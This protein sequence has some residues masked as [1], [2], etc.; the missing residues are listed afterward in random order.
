M[1]DITILKAFALKEGTQLDQLKQQEV[2]YYV[3][4]ILLP[5]AM[6]LTKGNKST[7]DEFAWV[8]IGEFWKKLQKNPDFKP[9]KK[10]LIGYIYTLMFNKWIASTENQNEPALPISE[11]ALRHLPANPFNVFEEIPDLYAIFWQEVNNLNDNCKY[12]FN[13]YLKDERSFK[14]IAELVSTNENNARQRYHACKIKFLQIMGNHPK[15]Q[16]LLEHLS[17]I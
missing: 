10:G 3:H 4:S 9:Q 8:A 13:L 1:D 11:E 7:A 12:L 15:I 14:E 5:N 2:F 6:K 16:E 17:Q